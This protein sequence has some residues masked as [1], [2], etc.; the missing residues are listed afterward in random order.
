MAKKSTT[1]DEPEGTLTQQMSD[2]EIM[3][4]IQAQRAENAA[5]AKAANGGLSVTET[6]DTFVSIVQNTART[7]GR[8]RRLT[9]Q[10]TVKILELSLGW[11]LQNRNYPSIPTQEIGGSGEESSPADETIGF[12]TPET[13]EE[14][15]A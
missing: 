1:P 15:A 12:E 13:T 4:A 9:E 10:T 3:A 8:D 11:V 6:F 5:K 14:N 7:Q 2:E